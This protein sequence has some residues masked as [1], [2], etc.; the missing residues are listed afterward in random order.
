MNPVCFTEGINCYLSNEEGQTPTSVLG[1]LKKNEVS[2][3]PSTF[4]LFRKT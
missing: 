1:L 3:P 4:Q 2:H